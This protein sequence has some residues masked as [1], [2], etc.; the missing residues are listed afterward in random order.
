MDLVICYLHHLDRYRHSFAIQLYPA[1]WI[2]KNDFEKTTSTMK[3][4]TKK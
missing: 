3:L 4:A 1:L 2:K